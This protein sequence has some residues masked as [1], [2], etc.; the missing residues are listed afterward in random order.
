VTPT[1]KLI[2]LKRVYEPA[3]KAD[4][5]RILVDRL[6]P[7]GLSREVLAVD[8]WVKDLAPSNELRQWYQHDP[9]KWVDFCRR[10]AL[11]LDR[12]PEAVAALKEQLSQGV[13]TFVYSSREERLNNAAALKAYLEGVECR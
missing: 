2:K 4:G 13:T 8:A 6:W 3:A 10:Y 5:R 12:Q 9:D 11:E 7:R 1:P